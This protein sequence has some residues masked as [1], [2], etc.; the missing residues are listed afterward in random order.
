[1]GEKSGLPLLEEMPIAH[2]SIEIPIGTKT[3]TTNNGRNGPRAKTNTVL[4]SVNKGGQ[5]RTRTN[6]VAGY[7]NRR[8]V[9]GPVY[10][11]PAPSFA[12]NKSLD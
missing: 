2:F 8:S 10:L 6:F 3:I 5:E 1:M 7:K 12:T 4:K 9:V 11:A